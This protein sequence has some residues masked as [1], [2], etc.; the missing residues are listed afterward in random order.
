MNDGDSGQPFE[1]TAPD[2]SPSPLARNVRSAVKEASNADDIERVQPDL[3]R[4]ETLA[5]N[6]PDNEERRSLRTA[7]RNGRAGGAER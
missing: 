5:D 4:L 1:D 7:A 2:D 3:G 6:Y